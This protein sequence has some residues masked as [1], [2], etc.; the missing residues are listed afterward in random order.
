MSEEKE[1]RGIKKHLMDYLREV[2]GGV[3]F[4]ISKNKF[5]KVLRKDIQESS[6][7]AF[8]RGYNRA[9]QEYER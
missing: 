7:L 6:N 5:N 2:E 4:P 8:G 1:I 3:F 9:R